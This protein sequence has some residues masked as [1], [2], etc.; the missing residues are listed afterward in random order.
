MQRS[1]GQTNACLPPGCLLVMEQFLSYGQTLQEVWWIAKLL[2]SPSSSSRFT[3]LPPFLDAIDCEA[4]KQTNAYCQ[5][6]RYQT[7]KPS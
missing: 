4:M 3:G 5:N 1:D 7:L 6:S 2:I